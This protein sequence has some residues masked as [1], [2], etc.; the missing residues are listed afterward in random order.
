VKTVALDPVEE[1]VEEILTKKTPST[2]PE[3]LERIS[4]I[5]F[6]M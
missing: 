4:T 6:N 1:L 5:S 3:D 2:T